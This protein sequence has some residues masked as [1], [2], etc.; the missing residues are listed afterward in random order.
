MNFER[1][2]AAAIGERALLGL[3][4]VG[5]T[6]ERAPQVIEVGVAAA[7]PRRP[8]PRGADDVA[9]ATATA[10]TTESTAAT[11]V[12]PKAEV[13]AAS[14]SPAAPASSESLPPAFRSRSAAAAGYCVVVDRGELF[15]FGRPT[16]ETSWTSHKPSGA[17]P[18]KRA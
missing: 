11:Q 8:L 3:D 17:T 13:R 4:G 10:A 14:A 9:D 18:R 5:A 15:V 2:S 16:R 7:A 1:K 6:A 12:R